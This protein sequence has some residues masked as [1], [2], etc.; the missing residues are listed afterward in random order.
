[1]STATTDQSALKVEYSLVPVSGSYDLADVQHRFA[2]LKTSPQP[3]LLVRRCLPTAAFSRQDMLL[4]NIEQALATARTYGFEPT[5]RHV[6]GHLVAYDEGS[7]VIHLL[8]GL[9]HS[10]S[11]LHQRFSV[12]AAALCEAVARL[13]VP[14]VRIG[15][16]ENEYCDGA[17][18]INVA[19][20]AKLAGTGQRLSKYGWA[21]SALLC[22]QPSRKVTDFL[23]NCYQQLDIELNPVTIGSVAD[24]VPTTSITQAATI[25]IDTIRKAITQLS[26]Q[27]T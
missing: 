10:P 21:W 1:M 4:P 2:M 5:I 3:T 13:G 15:S 11:E 23:T 20:I 16:I 27:R 7:L 14:E 25:V 6:G 17:W 22:V 8:S 19:G 18:S 26:P 12:L 9:Q 24:H